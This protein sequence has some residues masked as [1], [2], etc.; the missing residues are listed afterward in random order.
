[1]SRKLGQLR[2]IASFACPL[3]AARY[4]YAAVA[5]IDS[6]RAGNSRHSGGI[7][8]DYRQA[9]LSPAGQ[10][11]P[12]FPLSA[13]DRCCAGGGDG[14]TILFC[15]LAGERVVADVSRC[16]AVNR[17]LLRLAPRFFEENRPAEIASRMTADTAV[18]EQIV[19]T[20]VSVAARNLVIGI[21]GD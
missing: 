2:M 21:G 14:I 4:I 8:A 13:D 5:L 6:G 7:P 15:Q 1:M 19:G 17:N 11:R 20:T 12:L 16:C 3:S 18:I 9:A 10:Y